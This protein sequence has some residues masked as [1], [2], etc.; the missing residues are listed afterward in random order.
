ME[1]LLKK[2]VEFLNNRGIKHRISRGSYITIDNKFILTF[3]GKDLNSNLEVV[4]IDLS[5]DRWMSVISRLCKLNISKDMISLY[6]QVK[7]EPFYYYDQSTLMDSWH[8][9][10]RG[11]HNRSF[12][13]IKH[14]HKS[15]MDSRKNKCSSPNE[16]L[17]DKKNLFFLIK[18]RFIYS[19]TLNKE[20]ILNSLSISRRCPIVS[21]FSP[22]LVKDII[23]KYAPDIKTVI[24]PFSGFSGRMLGSL[25]LNKTYFG[26]DIRGD[27]INESKNILSFINKDCHLEVS[28]FKDFSVKSGDLLLTCPPYSVTELWK[29]VTSYFDEDYYIDWILKN[30]KCNK[31][32]FIVK[33]TRYKDNVVDTI[34]NG[35]WTKS[36]DHEKILIFN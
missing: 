33:N 15:L 27:V 24:D 31:Y 3:D 20:V 14:F 32:I 7:K 25:A 28:D 19:K 10:N 34:K 16:F 12:K 11:I 5:N 4:K 8:S 1:Y 26:G 23:T 36:N 18:N 9:I 35:S 17:Q 29:G 21:I 13:I 2:V 22:L 6:H 30:Y